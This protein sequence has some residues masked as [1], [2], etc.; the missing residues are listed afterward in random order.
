MKISKSIIKHYLEDDIDIDLKEVE[1]K[2]TK[3]GIESQS[4]KKQTECT[5]LIIGKVLEC[6]M[7]PNSDHLHICLVDTGKDKRQIVCGA[8]N[9]RKDLKVIVALPGAHLPGVEIKESVIRGEKSS[10]ML[11][12]LLELG[13]DKKDVSEEDLTGIH[14]I[15]ED[16]PL[17]SNAL[18]LLHLDDEILDLE[19]PYNRGDLMSFRG[20]MNEIVI[21]TNLKIKP[22]E[23]KI[24]K[25]IDDINNYIDL[26][27]ETDKVPLYMA[28]VV[29][30]VKIKE[31]PE[32]IKDALIKYG[33]KSINNVIDISNFVMLETGQ[34]LHFFDLES[35]AGHIKVRNAHLN[36]KLI[37]IDH[38]ERI[39]QED[40]I[41]IGNND[42]SLC[43]AGIMGGFNSEVKETTK[44]IVIESAIFD[45]KSIRLTSKRNIQTEASMRYIKKFSPHIS[46]K[47]LNL[48]A[49]LL[50]K[51]AGGEIIKGTLKHLNIKL[52]KEMIILRTSFIN[53]VLGTNYSDSIVE[54]A[55]K[56]LRF[57]YSK[58][59]DHFKVVVPSERI[60]LH[61]EIDLVEE[62]ARVQ[63]IN[64]NLPSTL[65]YLN[66]KGGRSSKEILERII[67]ETLIGFGFNEVINYNLESKDSLVINKE[68]IKLLNP[69]TEDHS[70]IR[71]SLIPSLINNIKENSKNKRNDMK[72]FEVA[73][74][75]YKEEE[76][77]KEMTLISG[78]LTGKTLT[79]S[80]NNFNTDVTFYTVKG[81]ILNLLD[82]LNI[83]SKRIFLDNKET[84]DYLNPYQSANIYI[85]KQKIGVMGALH[86]S[87]SKIKSYIFEIDIDT[88]LTIKR[89]KIKDKDIS[90][91]PS[92]QKDF[93]F[94][95]DKNIKSQDLVSL[96]K[97]EGGKDLRKVVIFDLYEGKNIVENK[98]SLAFSLIFQSDERTLTEEEVMNK[99]KTIIEKVEQE[100][101]AILR[102]N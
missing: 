71:T 76:E 51:Y 63:D 27:V 54:N 11:C 92:I 80:W 40:D 5:N 41:V 32:F 98:K 55:L 43:L 12:S 101:N 82:Y 8:P 75:Y 84:P 81:L 86:P 68:R 37:T 25:E 19:I 83:S 61:Q 96:I 13:I 33:I 48:A 3:L 89:G 31:T 95:I 73:N 99:F 15:K 67:K 72:L 17:G 24:N 49:Y 100:F 59:S 7:H 52:Y 20:L 2:L 14:E 88:L 44:D 79:S 29:K 46:E 78:I 47:A 56:K 102:D 22:L 65:P 93:A 45:S 36:E 42:K 85:D 10:G 26:K 35:F 6:R 50:E 23:T 97:R 9:V 21:D 62:I 34:P 1:K 94:I 70:Y 39:L 77:V 57:L 30:N 66:N 69:L 58:E 87:L 4:L 60:D 91:Y 53:K 64:D 28:R 38:T 90:I 18:E 74:T 16:F